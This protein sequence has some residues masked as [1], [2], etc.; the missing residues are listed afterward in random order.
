MRAPA[1]GARRSSTAV[2]LLALLLALTSL[3]VYPKLSPGAAPLAAGLS[4]ASTRT[5]DAPRAP[6]LSLTYEYIGAATNGPSSST[7]DGIRSTV[8]VSNFS[9]P[10]PPAGF[11]N[12]DRSS[13]EATTVSGALAINLGFFEEKNALSPSGCIGGG[14]Y[15]YYRDAAANFV[16]VCGAGPLA[17]GAH[18]F[19]ASAV[20]P[21]GTWAFDVDGAP[22]AGVTFNWT[23]GTCSGPSADGT[24]D[25]GSASVSGPSLWSAMKEETTDSSQA[26]WPM[27]NETFPSAM[28]AR[29]NGTWAASTV[30]LALAVVSTG[31]PATFG[32]EGERQNASLGADALRMGDRIAWPGANVA[33]WAP[34]LSVTLGSSA[35]DGPAPWSVEF[36]A[37]ATGGTGSY[38]TYRWTFGDGSTGEG[39]SVAH[40]YGAAGTYRAVVTVTD[41]GGESATSTNLTVTVSTAP[42]TAV[43]HA[44]F[45]A[46]AVLLLGLAVAVPAVL[47]GVSARSAAGRSEGPR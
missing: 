28:S 16:V 45:E 9:E 3:V 24:S 12:F 47:I 17:A 25:F 33:L 2:V 18:E 32:V 44:T 15:P 40:A 38:V 5:P 29:A 34:P 36:A 26:F 7:V 22:I 4:A 8:D 20:S 37:A 46:L 6:A 19:T 30:G 39:S 42:P 14:P 21:A 31:A 27:P 41:S 11:V 43:D 35:T 10:C 23:N 1:R 13:L